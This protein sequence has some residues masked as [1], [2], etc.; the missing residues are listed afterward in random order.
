MLLLFCGVAMAQADMLPVGGTA[1]QGTL[2][3]SCSM[4]QVFYGFAAADDLVMGE[5]VQQGYNMDEMLSIDPAA[6]VPSLFA[7]YPNPAVQGSPLSVELGGVAEGSSLMLFDQAGHLLMSLAVAD[8]I[9]HLPTTLTAGTY[10][11]VLRQHASTAA[12][13]KII[14]R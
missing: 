3:L 9:Y 12:V 6:S 7:V 2:S 11:A 5:G 4:G 13:K 1:Q 14:V 10:N 8:G